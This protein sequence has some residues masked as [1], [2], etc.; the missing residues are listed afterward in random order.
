MANTTLL[1]I[2]IA[3]IVVIIAIGLMG[4]SWLLTGRLKMRPGACG[5][6][7]HQDRNGEAGCGTTASCF[8]CKKPQEKKHDDNSKTS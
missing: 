4:I 3:F 8:L 7:P 6:N 2:G 1:T 5:R